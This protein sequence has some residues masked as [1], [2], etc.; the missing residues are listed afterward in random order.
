MELSVRD[1]GLLELLL[2]QAG[3][4][5]NKQKILRALCGWD[6]E[7]T[8][9]AVEQYVHRLQAK[10]EPGGVVIRTVRGLGY[11]LDRAPDDSG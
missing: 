7:I 8:L 5:V 3:R 10:L 6:N 1:W 11:M 9:N 2:P 4:I